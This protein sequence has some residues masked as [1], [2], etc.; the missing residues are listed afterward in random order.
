MKIGCAGFPVGR[1]RYWRTLSF[2]EAATGAV[3]P[4]PQTLAAWKQDAPPGAE[5]AVQAFRLLTHGPEDAGFPSA[6][7]R[8]PPARRVLCGA[9]RVSLEAHEAWIATKNAAA[10]LGARLVVFETPASFLPGP[11]RLRDLY[12][13]FKA[14]PRGRFACVWQPRGRGWEA[15]LLDKVCGDL[16]LVRAFDPLQQPLPKGRSLLYMR[17]S[18]P[19]L[20]GLPAEDLAALRRAADGAPAYVAFSHRDAFRDAAR[21]AAESRPA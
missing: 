9:F 16:G 6:G 18:G 8:L 2:V 20:G 15:S 1:D 5:F 14:L 10:A 3:M 17:P 11:D 12:R 7:R 4:Q 13:F 21:L 19:R